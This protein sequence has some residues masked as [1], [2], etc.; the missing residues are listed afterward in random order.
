VLNPLNYASPTYRSG[1]VLVSYHWDRSK[2]TLTVS[3][4][5]VGMAESSKDA[6]PGLGSIIVSS[7]N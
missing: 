4:D 6:K 3:D 1:K 2:G 5:G 7:G